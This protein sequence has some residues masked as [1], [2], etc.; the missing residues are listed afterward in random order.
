[1]SLRMDLMGSGFTGIVAWTVSYLFNVIKNRYRA[2]K[3]HI[4][5]GV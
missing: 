3:D 4:C 1:M 5:K 2:A